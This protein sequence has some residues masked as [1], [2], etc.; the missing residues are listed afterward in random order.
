M[1]Q[2]IEIG[3]IYLPFSAYNKKIRGPHVYIVNAKYDFNGD[4]AVEVQEHWGDSYSA[5]TLW[6]EQEED[7]FNDFILQNTYNLLYA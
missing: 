1:H 5:R 2:E 4:L 7:F 3:Q 6:F